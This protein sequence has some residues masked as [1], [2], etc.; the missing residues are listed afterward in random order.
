MLFLF[1]GYYRSEGG[2]SFL[3]DWFLSAK[4]DCFQE[5]EKNNRVEVREMKRDLRNIHGKP[6][7]FSIFL[8]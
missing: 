5:S 6:H 8:S 2:T 1:G 4:L 3:P 7:G